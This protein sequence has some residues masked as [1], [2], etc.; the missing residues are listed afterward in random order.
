MSQ[1]PSPVS[2]VNS[3]ADGSAISFSWSTVPNAADYEISVAGTTDFGADA[4]TVRT[5]ATNTLTLYQLFP[6][7]GR[8]LHWRVRALSAGQWTEWSGPARFIA[9][10]TDAPAGGTPTRPG[11]STQKAIERQS[12]RPAAASSQTMRQGPA[13]AAGPTRE[14]I[15]VDTLDGSA[16]LGRAAGYVGIMI[17]S[18]IVLLLVLMQATPDF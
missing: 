17:V 11:A 15:A 1:A 18:F 4:V 3:T 7:D 14:T 8:T 16:T 2:P 13:P 5:G 12:D 6:E 9:G 10:T